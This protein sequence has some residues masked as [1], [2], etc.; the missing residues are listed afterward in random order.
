MWNK[1]ELPEQWKESVTVCVYKKH[2]K[3]NCSN[4]QGI[5]LL[6]TTYKCPSNI[7]LSRLAP[8]AEEIIGDHQWECRQNRS[9][10]YHYSAFV[11]Y[12]RKDGNTMRQCI[13][14]L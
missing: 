9:T 2:D 12:L 13:S 3:M 5:S 11:K 14:Y 4:Y 1:E 6:S 8:Y 10:I 7:L